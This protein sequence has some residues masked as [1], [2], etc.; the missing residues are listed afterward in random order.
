MSK[1]ASSNNT[2]ANKGGLGGRTVKEWVQQVRE[3]GPR[4]EKCQGWLRATN[5]DPPPH[6]IQ[7]LPPTCPQEKLGPPGE[8]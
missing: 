7:E 1:L 6:T 2:R 3:P 4:Q 5:Q 8:V